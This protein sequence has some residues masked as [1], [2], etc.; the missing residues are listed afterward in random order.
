MLTSIWTRRFISTHNFSKF[1]EI[2]ISNCDESIVR[3]IIS[4]S[5]VLRTLEFC[6]AGEESTARSIIGTRIDSCD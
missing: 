1:R 2:Q 5:F 4:L 3:H 6:S